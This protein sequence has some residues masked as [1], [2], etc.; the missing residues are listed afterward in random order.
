MGEVSRMIIITTIH[1][2][3]ESAHPTVGSMSDIHLRSAR[4]G[5]APAIAQIYN[6]GIEDRL[7]TLE[8]TPR[9]ADERAE[10]LASRGPRHPVVVAEVSV[11]GAG[12][13]PPAAQG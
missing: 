6:Q 4:A 1:F 8:T 9:T 13:A 7:A 12:A 3:N 5:D 11:N 10:W 2:E